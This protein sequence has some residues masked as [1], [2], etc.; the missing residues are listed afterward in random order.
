MYYL[1][2]VEQ[3]R[4][5]LMKT[6]AGKP[7]NWLFLPGGPGLGSESLFTLI[8]GL[9]LEGSLWAI[10]YPGDGSNRIP[11]I[12]YSTWF[13]GLS[14]LVQSLSNVILVAHSF[15]GMLSLSVPA[16]NELLTGLV[17][18]NSAPGNQ[19]MQAL[20]DAKDRYRL[21]NNHDLLKQY[22]SLPSDQLLKQLSLASIPL[23]FTPKSAAQ[24]KKI[25]NDLP[26]N[27]QTYDWAMMNFHPHY[28][29]LWIPD[30]IPT[31]IIGGEYDYITPY[32]LFSNNN[33]FARNNIH[34][35]CI[36]DAGHF[37][38][39]D[40]MAIVADLF[41]EFQNQLPRY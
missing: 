16:L 24:G 29:H 2:T 11:S 37:A 12:D 3:Y 32:H 7:L 22:Y 13:S 10:D 14:N 26:F 40:D 30:K 25:L 36:K 38:W 31:L 9:N 34:Q 23:S 17:L 20:K 1:Y 21:V 15:A 28:Q 27:H 5:R 35:Y 6:Q 39:L 4:L 19:W 8:E 18:I 41:K 33:Q